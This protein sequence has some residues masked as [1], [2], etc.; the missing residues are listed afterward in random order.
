GPS[1]PS[2]HGVLR[3][4]VE[5]DGEV[6]KK[7]VPHVGYLHRGM[8]KIAESM[9]YHQFIPYTDRL[10]YL[11]PLSNNV[12]FVLAVEKLIGLEVPPR[13]RAIR[14]LCCEIARISAHLLWLGTGALDLGAATVFFHTFRERETLYDLIE[15][16]T[17]TRL[18]T[19]HPRVGG[20]ARDLPPNLIPELKDFLRRFPAQVDEYE[21]LLTRN[22]IWLKRTQDV[23][24]ISAEDAIDLGM[25]GPNL[26]GSGVEFDLRK[27][28]PYSGYEQYDFEVPVGSVGDAYDRYLVRIEEMRQSARILNQVADHMPEG[29]INTDDPK[30][31]LPPKQKVLTSMEELIHQFIIVTEGIP[32]PTGEIYHA[33]EAPKGELGFYVKSEGEKSPYRLKIRS[34]SFVSLQGIPLMAEGLMVSDLIAVVASLDPVMGEVDR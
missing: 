32:A 5:L 1:H 31:V 11:A 8:E 27:A 24:K 16:I 2:T 29:P 7:V 14:V 15:L 34:P 9:T 10:D 4:V 19:S 22:R 25:T 20:L 3:L 17:G 6:V 12:A 21:K 23:G 28:F 26:R 30:V 13:C 18:T 33:I